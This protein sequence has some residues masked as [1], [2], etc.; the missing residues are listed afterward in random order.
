MR[1]ADDDDVD[2]AEAATAC[3]GLVRAAAVTFLLLITYASGIC[4]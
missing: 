4:T 2:G 1:G 3:A